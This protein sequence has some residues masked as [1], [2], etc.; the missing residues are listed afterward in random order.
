MFFS[1]KYPVKLADKTYIPCIC[2]PLP[3]FL[4][5]TVE[6]LVKEEKAVIYD[7]MVFF[8]NG[9]VIKT[10]KMIKAEQK[11]IKKANKKKATV[12][13]EDEEGF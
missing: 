9:K 4:E 6:K 7:E 3:R 10:E 2:Y 5:M 11:E 12:K 1:V 13:K 8:Q